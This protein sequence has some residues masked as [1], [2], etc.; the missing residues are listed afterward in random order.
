M[1]YTPGQIM[2]SAVRAGHRVLV[3]GRGEQGHGVFGKVAAV[4]RLPFVL[5]PA[6]RWSGADRG[7]VEVGTAAA[8]DVRV[9]ATGRRARS[10]VDVRRP[11]RAWVASSCALPLGDRD[12]LMRRA[13]ALDRPGYRVGSGSWLTIGWVGP[14][15]PLRI[16]TELAAR[17]EAVGPTRRI[18]VAD[19]T[20]CSRPSRHRFAS[21]AF[22]CP[23]GVTIP[24]S[25]AAL[26]QDALT[27]QGTSIGPSREYAIG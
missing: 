4:A 21:A 25:D 19:L 20:S 18:G 23:D 17:L 26:T 3:G 24:I 11:A 10:A 14:G 22:P 5:D 6:A 12:P 13:I 27:S 9:D 16:S 8:P 2:P 1:I 15:R 7:A